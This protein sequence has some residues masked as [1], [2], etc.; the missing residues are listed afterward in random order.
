[1]GSIELIIGC[2]WSGKT[3]ELLRRV[4]RIQSI[5][6][7][8]KKILLVNHSIDKRYSIDGTATSHD[9]AAVYG[10]SVA[11]ITAEHLSDVMRS[12]HYNKATVIAIDEAQF[13]SDLSSIVQVM[14]ENDGK[15]VI[16][17]GLNGDSNRKKF[18]QLLDLIPVADDITFLSA[19]C[20]KCKD[21]TRAVFSRATA[22]RCA[23]VTAVGVGSD[24]LYVPVCRR[25]FID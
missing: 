22:K 23:A 3:T 16:A 24:E 8:P 1:M 17:S 15:Q 11:N 12:P 25:H 5:T 18:G 19:L 4:K 6:D 20:K 14:C 21:G 9:G 10:S 13:F 7:E 2:M